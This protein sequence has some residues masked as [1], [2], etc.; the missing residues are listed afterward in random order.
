MTT[1]SSEQLIFS[2]QFG[3]VFDRRLI[4]LWRKDL[5][6]D[7]HRVD[8]A[9]KQVVSIS[10]TIKRRTFAGLFWIVVGISLLIYIVGIIPLLTGI[11]MVWGSP[12]IIVGNAGG[13]AIPS[14]GFP[15]EKKAAEEF[16]SAIRNQL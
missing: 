8:I 2:N 12:M 6:T 5:S 1:N 13:E 11:C 14:L 15:W 10:Y 4:Y 3:Q 9:M 16:V 7:R